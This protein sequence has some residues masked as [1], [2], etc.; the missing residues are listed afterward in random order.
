MDSSTSSTRRCRGKTKEGKPCKKTAINSEWCHI[1]CTREAVPGWRTRESVSG[2]TRVGYPQKKKGLSSPTKQSPEEVKQ[3]KL[4]KERRK[5]DDEISSS[6]L[7]QYFW[8]GS[9]SEHTSP[10]MGSLG[11]SPTKNTTDKAFTIVE[12]KINAICN[13]IKVGLCIYHPNL[14]GIQWTNDT[15]IYKAAQLRWKKEMHEKGN[16]YFHVL[17]T[18]ENKPYYPLYDVDYCMCQ[19]TKTP[20]NN[21]F[22]TLTITGKVSEKEWQNTHGYTY[23]AEEGDKQ[24]TVTEQL[25]K[26]ILKDSLDYLGQEYKIHLQPK[27]E[28]QLPVLRILANLINTD[29]TF[30][31]NIEAWKTVI[32]YHRVKSEL[33][34]PVIVIYPVWGALSATLVLKKIIQIF[35]DYDCKE[36]GLDHTPRFNKKIGGKVAGLV[37]YANGSGDHKK[38][39]PSKYFTGPGK[40]FYIG[41]ELDI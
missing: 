15:N 26:K 10:D 24:R 12:N 35:K 2:G 30:R 32:P 6:L 38:K 37:Y 1:H 39:L 7:S 17:K 28:Y 40:E 20:E 19:E 27:P 3:I 41:H 16:H 31:E 5:G 33:N 34:L 8:W 11:W 13:T 21:A 9:D 14:P 23:A 22:H 29:T 36:I 25:K 4:Q 18:L